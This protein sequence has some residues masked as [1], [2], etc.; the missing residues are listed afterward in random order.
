MK[1]LKLDVVF[2]YRLRNVYGWRNSELNSN[3]RQKEPSSYAGIIKSDSA[4]AVGGLGMRPRAY[5]K[6]L[7][8]H[9]FNYT[10]MR[11]I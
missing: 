11:F 9:L 2:I 6:V 7:L 8:I 1:R 10:R 5:R 3:A 4:T